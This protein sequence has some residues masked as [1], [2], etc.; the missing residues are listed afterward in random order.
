[1]W[2]KQ[3]DHIATHRQP[4][5][6]EW[7]S[8]AVAFAEIADNLVRSLLDTGLQLNKIGIEFD[9]EPAASAQADRTRDAISDII[10]DLD[11]IIRDAGRA[12]IAVTSTL[13]R[14]ESGISRYR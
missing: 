8:D 5:S 6:G 13:P 2:D 1:M 12:V 9:R 14:T 4:E 3:L 10:D 7:D 11:R